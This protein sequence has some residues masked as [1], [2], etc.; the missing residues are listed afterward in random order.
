MRCSKCGNQT[1]KDK[2]TS[3]Q[4]LSR[5]RFMKNAGLA[6][7]GIGM[8][9]AVS[10][11]KLR[12]DNGFSFFN[13]SQ[14]TANFK[15]DSEGSLDGRRSAYSENIRYVA[16]SDGGAGIQKAA[17]DLG[18]YGGIIKLKPGV[19]EVDQTIQLETGQ[20]LEGAGMNITTLQATEELA[21]SG[22]PCLG[23]RNGGT[24]DEPTYNGASGFNRRVRISDL[25][26]QM[27][28][29]PEENPNIKTGS[30]IFLF[31]AYDC[32][33]ENVR[34]LNAGG[35]HSAG[36]IYVKSAGNVDA[37]LCTVRNCE[38]YN[39]PN[40]SIDVGS[41]GW[42]VRFGKAVGNKIFDPSSVGNAGFVHGI[43]FEDVHNS[44]ISNNMFIDAE[45]DP[46]AQDWN[47]N[48]RW[49]PALNVNESS[50]STITGNHFFGSAVACRM[51]GPEFNANDNVFSGNTVSD[52]GT[53]VAI[54]S[55]SRH[56]ITG[57]LFKGYGS[58]FGL[59]IGGGSH[60][61][62]IG[63]V[64]EKLDN[65]VRVANGPKAAEFPV[66]IANNSFYDMK[67]QQGGAISY[68]G[69]D[70][71][72]DGYAIIKDN[73][74]DDKSID[75]SGPRGPIQI[76][77]QGS[78]NF[79][80]E[81]NYIGMEVGG[82]SIVFWENEKERAIIRNNIMKGGV[83]IGKENKDIYGNLIGGNIEVGSS[84][85]VYNNKVLESGVNSNPEINGR[86]P[87]GA[88]R[89]GTYTGDGTTGRK[90]VTHMENNHVVVKSIDGKFF[91]V[92]SSWGK[93]YQHS[94][95]SGELSLA[96]NGFNVGDSNS[97]SHPNKDG[98]KY[99]F[100]A[101]RSR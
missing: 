69:H 70:P 83:I 33:V 34:T 95:P 91:D 93:G 51:N 67:E 59:S 60:A 6:A 44:V 8:S 23:S 7:A 97:D 90:I 39:S 74:I 92:H 49:A 12:S 17:D 29:R 100:M 71:Q 87:I 46:D 98:V 40:V 43:S 4:K 45:Y 76:A 19:Y 96:S 86:F 75:G 47:S 32:L 37:D 36:G 27:A 41:G 52:C 31:V 65:G 81:G 9:S 79:L 42:E 72:K 58:G 14:D 55:G 2:C 66:M 22:D 62:V 77:P 89:K 38:V 68:W 13:H 18:P 84:S 99:E 101:K 26:I 15:I 11:L 28:P 63:N 1:D 10:G 78:E 3:C 24:W 80:I 50:E 48:S 5:R 21:Q 73:Y 25:Q 88:D 64:F 16:A 56:M 54:S 82:A 94:K 30:A 85:L 57:N 35:D 61:N 53:G 20:K